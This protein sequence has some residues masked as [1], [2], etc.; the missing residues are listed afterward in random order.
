[1]PLQ[2]MLVGQATERIN[3]A[4]HDMSSGAGQLANSFVGQIVGNMNR[5]QPTTRV[6]LD[7]VDEFID[8]MTRVEAMMT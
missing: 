7:M 6:V 1:M 3:R 4:A 2:P 8:T 5:V